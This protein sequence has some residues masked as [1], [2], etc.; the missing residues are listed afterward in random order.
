LVSVFDFQVA[1]L[2]VVLKTFP[3]RDRFLR[4]LRAWVGFKQTG[5]PY[6]R[7]ERLFGTSTNSFFKNIW[8]AKKGIF[9]FSTK[10]LH[11]IQFLGVLVFFMTSFLG[12]YY[13]VNYFINPPSEGGKGITTVIMLVL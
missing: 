1:P 9:S 11:Y 6:V 3:E 2:S 5:V 4:G 7:P 8:W 13:L 10:P 12:L